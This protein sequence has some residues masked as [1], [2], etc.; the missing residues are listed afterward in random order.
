MEN[1][2]KEYVSLIRL[3]STSFIK[4]VA[5][6]LA[7]FQQCIPSC[8]C[9]R[10]PNNFWPKWISWIISCTMHIVTTRHHQKALASQMATL[11]S[12]RTIRIHLAAD[13]ECLGAALRVSMRHSSLNVGDNITKTAGEVGK[14][15]KISLFVK[16]MLL[17]ACLMPV[18]RPK[19]CRF[20]HSCLPETGF[21]NVSVWI[22]LIFK[23]HILTLVKTLLSFSWIVKF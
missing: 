4:A 9:S 1:F 21:W 13:S 5:M 2:I 18:L 6:I 7:N 3:L 23:C 20:L 19:S 22:L 10:D 15:S 14:Y 17:N 11:G 16:K 12:H 8:S